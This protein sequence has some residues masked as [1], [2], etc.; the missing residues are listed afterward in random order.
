MSVEQLKGFLAQGKTRVHVS[1]ADESS[2]PAEQVGLRDFQ[3]GNGE[4]WGLW[5]GTKKCGRLTSVA[6]CTLFHINE[7]VLTDEVLDGF[8]QTILNHHP[9]LDLLVEPNV[10]KFLTAWL[11]GGPVSSE[12]FSDLSAN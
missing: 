7:C 12:I 8:L 10:S 5:A 6:H 2:P 11:M 9:I 4:V 3:F 1:N